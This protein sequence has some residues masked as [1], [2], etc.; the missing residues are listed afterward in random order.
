VQRSRGVPTMNLF[1]GN[2]DFEHHLGRSGPRTL[3]A[4]VQSINAELAYSLVTIAQTGDLVWAA[5]SPDLDYRRHLAEIGLP[6]V[7]FVRDASDVAFGS[8]LLP[9]GWSSDVKAWGT[10]NGWRCDC[11]DLSVVATA[12]SRAFSSSLEREWNVGLPEA[13]TV[14]SLQEFHDAVDQ[15]AQPSAA[16]VVKA[17]FGMSAR[18]RILGCGSPASSQSV[19]WV[20]KQLAQNE[21]VYF[22]PWVERIEELGF[23]FTIPPA[24]EPVLEGITPLLTDSLGT[25]RGSR[26]RGATCQLAR[27]DDSAEVLAI[28]TR[29]AQRIQ[30]LGYFGPLG[31]DAMLYRTPD[32]Q[33]RWRPLQDINARLTMG[34]LALGLQRF[35]P[36][37][38]HATWLHL[39][40]SE[41]AIEAAEQLARLEDS[42]PQGTRAVRTSPILVGDRPTT[43]VSFLVTAPTVET[44]LAAEAALTQIK[45]RRAGL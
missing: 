5:E 43:R 4:S 7:Q 18:E 2:F 13:R 28:V 27:V 14:R 42:L 8:D 44:L 12:N 17:N 3:P 23:Q 31:I 25:Y 30:Q 39:R 6:D 26:L 38:E 36:E 45:W 37:A 11:P 1:F 34:R 29:A 16:W 22:E 24:G 20:Q 41:T 32:G 21:A 15:A 10:R 9:W 33:T 35:F 40:W 19:R